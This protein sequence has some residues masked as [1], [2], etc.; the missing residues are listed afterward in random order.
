MGTAIPEYTN[1]FLAVKSVL[2]K[3]LILEFPE[4]DKR[5]VALEGGGIWDMN[6]LI[7]GFD[8]VEEPC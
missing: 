1:Q 4:E 3:G 8:E 5:K 2:G 6:S 7:S